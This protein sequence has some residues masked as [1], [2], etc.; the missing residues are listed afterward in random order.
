MSTAPAILKKGS[1]DKVESFVRPRTL[2]GTQEVEN[3]ETGPEDRDALVEE[4]GEPK[5]RR[6]RIR[7]SNST[8]ANRNDVAPN[9]PRASQ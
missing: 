8:P 7:K 5:V 4:T 3:L 9:T 2:R 1:S 6:R